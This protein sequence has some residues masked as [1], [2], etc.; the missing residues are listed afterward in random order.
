MAGAR[1]LV[2]RVNTVIDG[3]EN[4]DGLALWLDTAKE[5]ARG[6]RISTPWWR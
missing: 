4:S 1:R 6:V 3:N 2:D 5:S